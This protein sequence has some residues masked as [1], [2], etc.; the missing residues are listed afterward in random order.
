[1]FSML[2]LF[3]H[4][5]QL[6]VS[7]IPGCDYYRHLVIYH[8]LIRN[9]T[10]FPSVFQVSYQVSLL[11]S[12]P[13]HITHASCSFILTVLACTSSSTTHNVSVYLVPAFHNVLGG[14]SPRPFVHTDTAPIKSLCLS[15]ASASTPACIGSHFLTVVCW[16]LSPSTTLLV[17]PL[18]VYALPT[19][20][21]KTVAACSVYHTVHTCFPT[22]TLPSFVIFLPITDT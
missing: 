10:L 9:L 12:A 13:S 21:S 5:L 15:L 22:C 17:W 20:T 14:A 4:S 7:V 6:G 3:L 19:S 18:W 16:L 11:P 2:H 8:W 1:M